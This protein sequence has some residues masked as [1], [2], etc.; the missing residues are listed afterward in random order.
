MDKFLDKLS[1]YNL[2]NN[3][4]PGAISCFLINVFWGK[5]IAGSNIVESIFIYYFVGM[6]VSRMGSIIVEPFCKKCQ[7]VRF[8]DYSQYITA[9]KKDG[10]LEILSETNNIFRTMLTMCLFLLIGKIYFYIGLK[11]EAIKNIEKELLLIVLAV[12]FACS[13]RKQTKYIKD[14][15]EKNLNGGD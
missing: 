7:L 12:L 13:Y 15:V 1:S 5:N 2:L 11:V 4:F 6:V 14:R 9:S 10:K 8:A 3:V